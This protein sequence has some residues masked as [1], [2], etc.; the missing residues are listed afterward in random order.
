M[1]STAIA[2]I[3]YDAV[4]RILTISYVGGGTYDYIGVEPET[5]RELLLARAKGVFVNSV[6]KRRYAFRRRKRADVN[7]P[8]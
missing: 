3:A 7:F 5:H 8:D 1:P 2:D 4:R 6:I